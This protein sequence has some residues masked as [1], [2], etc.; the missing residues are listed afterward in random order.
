MEI[1]VSM[2]ERSYFLLRAEPL[3]GSRP[4]LYSVGRARRLASISPRLHPTC[5]TRTGVC[6]PGRVRSRRALQEGSN[7]EN[8][9]RRDPGLRTIR[10]IFVRHPTLDRLPVA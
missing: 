5:R 3:T 4:P 8:Q 10:V 9:D 6:R 7:P 2:V 1:P